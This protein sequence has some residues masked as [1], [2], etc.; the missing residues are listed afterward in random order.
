MFYLMFLNSLSAATGAQGGWMSFVP[1]LLIIVVFYFLLI[2][3]QN[4]QRAKHQKFLSEIKKGDEVITSSGIIATIDE[5]NDKTVVLK[6]DE[7]TK[8]KMLRGMISGY[9]KDSI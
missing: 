7:N 6:F 5:I 2:R 3:P 1:L 4:K 9:S 8:V